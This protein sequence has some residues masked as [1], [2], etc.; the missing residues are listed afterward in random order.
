MDKTLEY[1]D[2]L[3]ENIKQFTE[4]G[5]GPVQLLVQQEVAIGLGLTFQGVN[6]LNEGNNFGIIEPEFGSPYSLT[7]VGIVKGRRTKSNVEEV[8]SYII[9]DILRN[10]KEYYSPDKI[11]KEQVNKIE[12]YPESIKYAD[13]TGI[14]DIE[15]KERLLAE[16][17]Y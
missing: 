10:D 16:W 15:E 3:A 12:N 9:T 4:S 5:S 14:S 8:Y 13:M 17:K 1:F 2:K 7:G 6:E 11:L